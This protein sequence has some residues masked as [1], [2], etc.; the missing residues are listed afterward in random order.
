[1]PSP[2][3]VVLHM[4]GPRPSDGWKKKVAKMSDAQVFA[5]YKREQKKSEDESTAAKQKI[6]PIQH[7]ITEF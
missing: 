2:R 1:M 6:A 7:D 5:I 4:Y 3:D